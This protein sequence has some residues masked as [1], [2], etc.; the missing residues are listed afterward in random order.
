[1]RPRA[2]IA[3]AIALIAGTIIS[4]AA[5]SQS[6]TTQPAT[7]TTIEALPSAPIVPV[8]V[9]QPNFSESDFRVVVGDQS[10]GP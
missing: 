8:P 1:M 6:V 3:L 4:I 7:V 5:K 9:D 10:A 2:A